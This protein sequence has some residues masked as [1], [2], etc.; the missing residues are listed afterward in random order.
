MAVEGIWLPIITPFSNDK[1]DYSSYKKLVNHYIKKGVTGIIPLGTTGESPTVAEDEFEKVVDKTVEYVNGRVPI[2][3]GV[4]GNYT[5]KVLKMLKLVEKYEVKGILSVSPYYN[6]PDQRGIYQHFKQ[7]SEAT[8]L[9]II[10]YNIPYRTG[11]NIEN[12]TIYKLA[13]LKNIVALKDA[14]GDAKQSMELLLNPPSDLSILTG[15]DMFFYVTM[16][17]GGQGGILASAHIG[18]EY[19]LEVYR[20]VKQNDHQAAYQVWKKLAAFIPL[21]FKE[22]NPAPIKYYLMKQG[23][24]K[25]SETRLPLVEIT[26]G[27]KAQ[28]EQV[29]I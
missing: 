7:L 21:L 19:F 12:E 25:S 3:V 23:L 18:T 28:L 10:V 9:D 26:D 16:T 15:E 20:L 14:S 22:P 13:E 17:H 8:K 27:L 2:Y 29:R 24:I 1:V 5:K 6:R 11:R 4:G